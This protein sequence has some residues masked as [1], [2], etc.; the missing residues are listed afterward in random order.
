[1]ALLHGSFEEKYEVLARLRQGG[2]GAV[3]KVRHRLLT[4]DADALP[5]VKLIDLGIAK[6]LEDGAAATDAGVFLGKPRYASPE[7]FDGGPVDERS[8]LYSFGVVLYELLTGRCPI[9]GHD[10]L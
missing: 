1:M 6:A 9:S 4:R 5:L 10:A 2:M 3:Y 8:D 7:Q